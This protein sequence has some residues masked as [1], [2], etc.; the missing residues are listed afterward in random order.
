MKCKCMEINSSCPW[1]S[2]ARCFNDS[3]DKC[4][5]SIYINT[6]FDDIKNSPTREAMAD[7]IQDYIDN[8]MCW[9]DINACPPTVEEVKEWL[10]ED[11]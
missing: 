3:A 10:R 1:N 5:Y 6:I 2:N 8:Y 7:I 11:A 9:N 4:E